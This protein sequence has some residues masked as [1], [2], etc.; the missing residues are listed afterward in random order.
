MKKNSLNI[1]I[2]FI[3]LL[4]IQV[5]FAQ[6][7]SKIIPDKRL[8]ECFT[9]K[10]IAEMQKN[11]PQKI[12][13]YNYYLNNSYYTASLKAEKPIEGI[14]IHTVALKNKPDS[15]FNENPKSFNASTFNPLK[16]NFQTSEINFIVYVWK[17][18]GIALVMK[19][20]KHVKEEFEMYLK[21]I[22]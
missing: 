9:A 4:A 19:P 21:T 16:Y 2:F 20:N 6:S 7:T 5:L 15:K 11:D 8:N 13:Y 1:G 17:E 22:K 12:A 3:L 14:D 10:Q 18:A